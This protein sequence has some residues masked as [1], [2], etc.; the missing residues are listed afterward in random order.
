MDSTITLTRIGTSASKR[1]DVLAILYN[2]WLFI[3]AFVQYLWQNRAT[4]II[5]KIIFFPIWGLVWFLAELAFPFIKCAWE[6]YGELVVTS[7]LVA[8]IAAL[9]WFGIPFAMAT[10]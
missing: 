8:A 1:V 2:V 7:V 6:L 3:V 5:I 10:W 9:L 4:R